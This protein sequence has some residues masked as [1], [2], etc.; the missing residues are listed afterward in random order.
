[1]KG[2]LLAGG[3]GTRLYPLTLGVSKQLMPVYDK[4]MIY[5]PLSVLMLAGIRDILVITTPEQQQNFKKLLNDGSQFGI[6][7]SYVVQEKPEGIAQAFMLGESFIQE[8]PVALALGDN[9]FFGNDLIKLLIQARK[10]VESAGGGEIFS[11]RVRD[12]ERYGVVDQNKE[13]TVISIEEKPKKPKSSNAVVGLYFYDSQVIEYTKKLKPSQ[14]GELEITDL[15]QLYLKKGKLRVSAM[16]RGYAWLDTG[17]HHDL[18]DAGSFVRSIQERQGLQ[19]AC[20]EEIAF[21]AG[22]IDQ[23]LLLKQAKRF[24]GNRYG[25]YL[26]GLIGQ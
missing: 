23:K 8:E 24:Q 1:M 12:P 22:W 18:H 19:I 20:P 7:L 21:E 14:R 11:Y 26:Y 13:G 6:K 5:Y 3:S 16:G 15:N 17:T 2:I 9:L 4:P 10:R 25:E